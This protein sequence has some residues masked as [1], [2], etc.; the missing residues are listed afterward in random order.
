M[1]PLIHVPSSF[2]LGMAAHEW[3][4]SRNAESNR[5]SKIPLRIVARRLR[6]AT[7]RPGSST[8]RGSGDHHKISSPG[9]Y[10]GKMPRR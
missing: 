3:I 8:H 10:Q 5:T 7:N 2:F 4:T 9:S 6:D 1:S